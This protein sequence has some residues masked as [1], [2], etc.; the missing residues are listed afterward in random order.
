MAELSF[1]VAD[2]FGNNMVLQRDKPIKIWG[3]SL[4]EQTL[5]VYINNNEV[6]STKTVPGEWQV[7][8]PPMQAARDMMV[9]ITG[10]AKSEE[11]IYQHVAV[12]EVWVAGGQSNMEFAL[13]F[14]AEARKVI[15]T[16]NNPDIRFYDCP[17]IKFAGQENE[18]DYSQFGF[19]RT[20]TPQD[21]PYFSAVGFY[22]ANKLYERYQVPIGIVGCNWGG[23]TAATW[24]DER[25]LLEDD[26]I[27]VYWREYQQ[28][29]EN[30]DL[31]KHIADEKNARDAMKRPQVVSTMRKV[32][33]GTLGPIL[34]LILKAGMRSMGR[35]APVLGPH[36]ENRPG[37]LYHMMLKEIAGF[38][39]RGVIWYQGESDDPKAGMYARLFTA[40]IRCWR[41]AWQDELPF[42]YVQLAPWESWFAGSA[43][44]F[45]VIRE[46][47]ELVSKT[48]P[49]AHMVSIMDCGEKDDI[50]PKHKRP[51]GERLALLARGKVYGETILC[52]A[53]EAQNARIENGELIIPFLNTGDGLY[54]KGRRLK[55]LE[56][57]VDGQVIEPKGFSITLSSIKVKGRGLS[58]AKAIEIRF[59]YRNYAEINLYNSAGLPAKPFRQVIEVS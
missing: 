55:S 14:D 43:I 13:E 6:A 2:I 28:G 30:L 21:A 32:Q 54:L 52:D 23:T 56:L 45:Q 19:W 44:N 22:F 24:M 35:K 46:Q 31:E 7:T 20:L 1:T 18:D 33:K 26:E 10:D 58:S 15:R 42:L 53:P 48:V 9:K 57:T 11:I 34:K 47:Q 3:T 17:K 12:G 50:H 59:A 39:A 27:S 4:V 5:H 40:M 25:Y 51:V 37:G 8:M 49:G 16:A 36:S 41:D 29:I 38:S